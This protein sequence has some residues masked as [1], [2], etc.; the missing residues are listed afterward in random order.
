MENKVRYLKLPDAK[1]GGV[2]ELIPV[3]DIISM[4]VPTESTLIDDETGEV[5]NIDIEKHTLIYTKNYWKDK[6]NEFYI[7]LSLKEMI[8][9][10]N[11]D[12]SYPTK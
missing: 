12:A 6:R 7:P 2:M 4:N 3:D 9:L 8:N 10:V 11:S 5:Y 1:Q